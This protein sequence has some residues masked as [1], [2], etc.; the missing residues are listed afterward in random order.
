[1]VAPRLVASAL[2]GGLAYTCRFAAVGLRSR[3]STWIGLGVFLVWELGVG[4]VPGFLGRLTLVT[5]VRSLSGL[6][7]DAG[8]LGRLWEPVAWP[9][10]L[11]ALLG[12]TALSLALGGF[13]AERREFPLAR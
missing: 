4:A 1:G 10:S 12:V 8:V 13:W 11:A 5:H 7:L 3:G 2:L 6:G 9:I